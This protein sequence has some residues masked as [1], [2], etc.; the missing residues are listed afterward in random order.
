MCETRDLGIM[1]PHWHTLIFE[2]GVRIGHE[3]CLPKR[4]EEHVICSRLGQSVGRSGQQSMITK[5]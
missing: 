3:T 2:G 1:W 4:C 5:N